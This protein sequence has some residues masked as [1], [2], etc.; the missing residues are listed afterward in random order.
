MPAECAL[1]ES[2]ETMRDLSAIL[3]MSTCCLAG[4]GGPQ[5]ALEPAG[6]DAERMASLFVWLTFGFASIWLAVLALFLYAPR[7]RRENSERFA[8]PLILGGGV[9]LPV[10]VL[11]LLMLVGFSDLPRILAPAPDNTLTIDVSGSQWWWR[12]RYHIRNRESVELANEIHL[13]RGRRLNTLVASV[14]V[15]HSFWIPSLAGKMDMIP[16]RINRLAIEPTRMGTFRGVCAEYCGTSHAR[17]GLI[18]VVSDQQ[19]FDA[20]LSNQAQPA[21]RPTDPIAVRGQGAFFARGCNVCHT[22]RG[23]DAVGVSGPD[24]THVGSRRSLAAG[25]LPMNRDELGRWI[26]HTEILKPGVHMP[27]FSNLPREDLDGLAA[28]LAHLQ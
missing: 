3:L 26:S 24:L 9:A 17:M 1:L 19:T 13:P 14:D 16:G 7:A 22:I 28:Y 27:A 6:R 10:V 8:N 11:S 18:A 23:T 25:M 4:C 21:R 15:V 2:R 20:W 5:S 12:V